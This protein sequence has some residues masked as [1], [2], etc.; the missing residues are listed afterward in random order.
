M[1]I[2]YLRKTNQSVDQCLKNLQ[3]IAK[4]KQINIVS[5]NKLQDNN[6]YLI[7]FFDEKMF[8]D[9]L[10]ADINL[11]GLIPQSILIIQQNNNTIV[12]TINPELLKASPNV[13]Q[14]LA[15]N[16][17][18]NIKTLINQIAG[19]EELKIKNIKLYA[20][21]SCPY[22]KMEK[23]YLEK[24]KIK[25]DYTLVDLNQQAAEEMIIKTGQN[26]VPVTELEF[27]DGTFDYI[28]GF[29]KNKLDNL[30]KIK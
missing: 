21:T 3:N 19:V 18:Q 4:E 8:N 25:F 5:T 13:D 28:I 23:A 2:S 20:T 17:E 7:Y 27:E 22:C 30:L 14:K 24:N 9:L 12:S 16:I 26:G 29:D 1:N 6:G 10:K 15:E 11:I